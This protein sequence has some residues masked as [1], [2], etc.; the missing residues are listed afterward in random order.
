MDLDTVLRNAYSQCIGI[1]DALADMKKIAG[2]NTSVTA[3]GT[4]LGVGATVAGL[5][6]SAKDKEIEKEL[7]KLKEIEKNR[8][9]SQN[10]GEIVVLGEVSQYYLQHQ[11]PE[12]AKEY[13]RQ[14]ETLTSDSKKLGNWRTGLLAGNTVTNVVGAVLANKN[15]GSDIQKHINK[16][17][18][19]VSEL[20]DALFQARIN[21]QDV[22]DA[23]DIITACSAYN[24][25]DISKIIIR[26]DGAKIS[27]I[28]GAGIGGVGTVTSAM[29]N[30]SNVRN[31]DSENGKQKEKILNV[32][33]N[34][35]A[36]G[37]ASASLVATIFNAT[38]IS[39]IKKAAEAAQQCEKALRG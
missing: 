38:Q 1:D 6:K 28:V 17:R 12:K 27:S 39:A 35:L 9:L 34:A 15:D 3:V 16:C 19:A 2:I 33:S 5:V 31:D 29:A 24:T 26:A 25:V 30:S 20:N 10:P 11:N 37:A 4:G 7:Q 21:R 8:S 18:G 36:I 14:I 13:Q 23:D 32:T 22:A